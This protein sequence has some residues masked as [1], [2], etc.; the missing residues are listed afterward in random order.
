PG[1]AGN[2]ASDSY[3]D[4]DEWKA[5]SRDFPDEAKAQR[6][7]IETV[8]RNRLEAERVATER[9]ARLEERLEKEVAPRLAEVSIFRD[10]ALQSQHLHALSAAHP[11]WKDINESPEFDAW[12]QAQPPIYAMA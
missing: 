6:R 2:Q 9:Y 11:D 12:V 10:Q 7:L 1:P 8:E 3:F 5:F 4:S